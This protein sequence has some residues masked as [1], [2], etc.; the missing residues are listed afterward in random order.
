MEHPRRAGAAVPGHGQRLCPGDG[1]RRRRR[2]PALPLPHAHRPRPHLPQR[3]DRGGT[4]ADQHPAASGSGAVLPAD[5]L[6][7]G[8][9][10]QGAAGH[11]H[12]PA[13]PARQDDLSSVGRG[14]GDL[15][16]AGRRICA[17]HGGRY[18]GGDEPALAVDHGLLSALHDLPGFGGP[19]G[20][21][22]AAARSRAAAGQ[23]GPG[24]SPRPRGLVGSAPAAR[25]CAARRPDQVAG[26][27]GA[28]RR[29]CG[30]RA[31]GGCR[32][33]ERDGRRRGP[34]PALGR[35]GLPDHP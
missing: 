22:E 3:A 27:P 33:S 1:A 6:R 35:A 11:G 34:R 5:R 25:P 10:D 16:P 26:G 2:L 19:A 9:R 21:A 17:D 24:H 28:R 4:G 12:R 20:A 23:D 30:R 8:R 18:A 29:R 13:L 15:Q 32:G 7:R 14:E 31:G